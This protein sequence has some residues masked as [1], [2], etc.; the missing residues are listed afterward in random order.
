M[1]SNLLDRPRPASKRS[2]RPGGNPGDLKPG[3]PP[4]TDR[5]PADLLA[6]HLQKATPNTTAQTKM[7][8]LYEHYFISGWCWSDVEA[9]GVLG[10]LHSIFG[11]GQHM[12][13]A[14]FEDGLQIARIG[15]YLAIAALKR[16]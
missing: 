1:P 15:S 8:F 6:R 12:L 11:D 3:D 9:H 13:P 2:P 14:A 5:P 10:F 4:P 16:L 7:A